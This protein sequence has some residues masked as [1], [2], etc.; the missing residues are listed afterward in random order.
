MHVVARARLV[1]ARRPWVYWAV[2]AVLA[3]ALALTVDARLTSLD[4]ARR[5]WGSTRTVLVAERPLEPGDPFDVRPVDL[6]MAAIP[7]GA[8]DDLPAGA[9][10][11]QR[12]GI[13]EVL[14]DLDLTVVH[15]PAARAPS[16]TVVVALTDPLSR[17][18]SIGLK[19][20][21]AADGLVIAESATVVELSDD[22]IFVAVDASAAPT[23][24]VAAQQGTASL[25]YLP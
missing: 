24:A 10:L 16:G 4:E 14:T 3:S 23:V 25:L 9:Q 12:V 18:V 17:G 19:V 1:L 8:L 15:G 6:P 2:V 7:P 13:A 5:N 22:V 21:V 11:Q 20:Q